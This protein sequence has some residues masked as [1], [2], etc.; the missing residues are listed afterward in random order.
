GVGGAGGGGGGE[1]GGGGGGGGGARDRRGRAGDPPRQRVQVRALADA[2][3]RRPGLGGRGDQDRQGHR[4]QD[5]VRP[6][7]GRALGNRPARDERG[8][9]GGRE[10][11]APPVVD[12]LPPRDR[13][14]P[15][16]HRARDAVAGQPRH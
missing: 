5:E 12:H 16:W 1:G 2:R 3:R 9:R 4:D 14:Q 13:R 7:A 6:H 11:R 10:E 8:E 15:G